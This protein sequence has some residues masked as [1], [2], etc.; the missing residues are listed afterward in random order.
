MKKILIFSSCILCLAI[1]IGVG[2]RHHLARIYFKQ[3]WESRRETVHKLDRY[4]DAILEDR[5]ILNSHVFFKDGTRKSNAAPFMNSLKDP[6]ADDGWFQALHQFDH[7][8]LQVEMGADPG[9]AD[10]SL[11]DYR[12]YIKAAEKYFHN[13]LGTP[14]EKDALKNT[15]QLARLFWTQD[16]VVARSVALKLLQQEDSLPRTPD[17]FTRID[18]EVRKR[19]GRYNRVIS[20]FFDL[21]LDPKMFEEFTQTQYSLCLMR[22]EA[23]LKFLTTGKFLLNELPEVFGRHR[24]LNERAE[25]VCPSSEVFS[26]WRTGFPPITTLD[27]FR[28]SEPDPKDEKL[29]GENA[30]PE[31]LAI[32]G[33]LLDAIAG[34]DPFNGYENPL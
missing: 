11:P 28:S 14:R 6:G 34:P 10:V 12:P 22:Y 19:A 3:R 32:T 9:K 8:S 31:V 25:R 26:V 29:T 15:R 30:T 7:W 20:A 24:S 5:S 21:H 23:T 33:Y 2:F 17:D 4:R 13:A 18:Q 16:E 27:V 1:G